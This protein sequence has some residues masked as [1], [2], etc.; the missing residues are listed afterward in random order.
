MVHDICVRWLAGERE[1]CVGA[2]SGTI[3]RFVILDTRSKT[4]LTGMTLNVSPFA[5]LARNQVTFYRDLSRAGVCNH[6]GE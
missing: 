6:R 2:Q 3:E 5:W 4:Q 1:K